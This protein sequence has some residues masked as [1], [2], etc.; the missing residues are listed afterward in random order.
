MCSN[1]TKHL[2]TENK[3]TDLS[4]SFLQTSIKRCY[5]SLDQIYFTGDD[6]Y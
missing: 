6:G 5:F 1:K 2:G 4:K 3:I